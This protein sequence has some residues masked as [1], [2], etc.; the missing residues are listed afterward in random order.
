[1]SQCNLPKRVENAVI[2][3]KKREVYSDGDGV[4]YK[5]RTNYRMEGESIIRCQRGQWTPGTPTC[6]Q[7]TCRLQQVRGTTYLDVYTDTFLPGE[8][9]SVNCHQGYWFFFNDQ[10][11]QKTITC[12]KSGKWN[13]A[14]ECQV[15]RCQDPNDPNLKE[16][17]RSTRYGGYAYYR[18]KEGFRPTDRVIARCR[19]VGL[20]GQLWGGPRQRGGP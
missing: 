16:G 14:A 5:C 13:T 18:C 8:T 9:V 15:I 11:T 17:L 20:R 2:T 3:E 7:A 10:Q 19:A 6:I 4:T 12:T 1:P